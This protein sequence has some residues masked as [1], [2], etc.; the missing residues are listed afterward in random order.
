ML[1]SVKNGWK[2]LLIKSRFD[3]NIVQYSN[4]SQLNGLRHYVFF[5]KTLIPNPRYPNYIWEIDGREINAVRMDYTKSPQS[6]TGIHPSG[7]G[8]LPIA[9]S[10]EIDIWEINGSGLYRSGNRRGKKIWSQSKSRL[11][12]NPASPDLKAPLLLSLV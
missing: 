5:Q 2:R 6:G 11:H 12:L 8:N 7:V 9:E 1:K 10:R 3:H 4:L